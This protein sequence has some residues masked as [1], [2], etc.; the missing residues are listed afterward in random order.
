MQSNMRKFHTVHGSQPSRLP[1]GHTFF[2]RGD[3]CVRLFLRRQHIPALAHTPLPTTALSN[4]CTKVHLGEPVTF[5]GA[6][7]WS[8][9]DTKVTAWRKSPIQMGDHSPK[10]QPLQASSPGLNCKALLQPCCSESPP[11]SN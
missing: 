4:S 11:G 7:Y 10:Q 3:C 8:K 1:A 5:F 6:T 9:E 2:F